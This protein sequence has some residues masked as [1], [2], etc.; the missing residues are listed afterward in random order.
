MG[1]IIVGI[2]YRPPDVSID[3]FITNT[4]Y[5]ISEI[6]KTNKP[7]Y[8]LG[9]WNINLMN[10]LNHELT[11]KFLDI[12]YTNMFLPLITHPTRITSCSKRSFVY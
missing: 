9:D 11:S 6:S 12:M 3:E 4:E 8:I 1:N 2:V 5:L 7:C 10:H